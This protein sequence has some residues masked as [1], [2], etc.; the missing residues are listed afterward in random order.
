IYAAVQ[1]ASRFGVRVYDPEGREIAYVPT[2]T[3]PTNVALAI[4]GGRSYLYVTGGP[5]LYRIEALSRP[6]Q[7]VVRP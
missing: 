7:A 3:R 4:S 5:N 2:P 6:R 1:A